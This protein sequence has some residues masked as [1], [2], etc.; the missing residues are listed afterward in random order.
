[1]QDNRPDGN[2]HIALNLQKRNVHSV[3][4][5]TSMTVDR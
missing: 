3:G 1:M 2:T 4:A 5:L